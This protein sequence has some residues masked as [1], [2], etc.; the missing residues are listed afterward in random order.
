MSLYQLSE[1]GEEAARTEQLEEIILGIDLG[2]TNSIVSIIEDGV[3]RVIND[4][5]TAASLIPS[6][7][8]YLQDG[9]VKI[10]HAALSDKSDGAIFKSIKRVMGKAKKDADYPY[11]PCIDGGDSVRFNVFGHAISPP[12]ISAEILL[13]LKNIAAESLGKDLAKAVITVPAYFDENA[14][15]ATKDAARLAGIEVVRLLNEPTAAAVAYGYDELDQGT[16]VVFDLGGGTF[17]ITILKMINGVFQVLATSGDENLGGDDFDNALL[18]YFIDKYHVECSGNIIETILAIR[19]I[20][21]R[22][23]NESQ[24]SSVLIGKDISISRVQYDD[25][26]KQLVER[27]I[28]ITKGALKDAGLA[29]SDISDVILVGGSTRTPLIQKALNEYFG[30]EPIC[31][32]DP[33]MAV[34]IGAARQAHNLAHASSPL[35]LDVVPLSLAIEVAG[36]L[37]EK[38]IYRNTPLPFSK[39]LMFTTQKDGQTGFLIHVLQGEADIVAKCRSIARFEL[40]GIASMTAGE[41]RL[42]VTFTLDVDGLLSVSAIEEFSKVAKTVEVKPS[43]GLSDNEIEKLLLN[44]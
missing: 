33:D 44:K 1:P 3:S 43:Y 16:Y 18:S 38:I 22:L 41:A 14:R 37:V 10:G 26:I 39:S 28:N 12:A 5:T 40:K 31:T 29:V 24:V 4:P 21:E 19:Q 27:T 34:A 30:K 23:S 42:E 32:I 9:S 8:K 7:V 11:Y 15:K 36:G 20:K 6:V 2:T 13:Y 25:L 35:L 17:D